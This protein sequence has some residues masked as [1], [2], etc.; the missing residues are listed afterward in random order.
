MGR[1]GRTRGTASEM[2]TAN[3][4]GKPAKMQ[5]AFAAG[6]LT[7]LMAGTLLFGGCGEAAPEE[8][9]EAEDTFTPTDDSLVVVGVS[10]L[11]SESV[12]RT[13]HTASIQRVFTKENGYFLIFENARQK[14]ENQLKAIRSFISQQVDYIVFS[15]ITE[16]GW[17][18]VLE[19][20]RDAGI[21]VILM[22]REVQVQDESLYT[23]WVGSD[24]RQEGEKAGRWLE[25]YL[26]EQSRER[27][28]IRIVILEGT[29]GGTSTIGRNE[30]F[31]AVAAEH[32]NWKILERRDAEF[33]TAKGKEVM[34]GMLAR[35]P[36]IDVVVS[37]NDDMTLGALEALNEAG[38][39]TGVGGDVIVISFDAVHKA[40]ELVADGVINVDIEC[41]PE[42]GEYI[43]EVIRKMEAGEEIDRAYYVPEEVFTQENVGDFLDD[44]TY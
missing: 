36:D 9:T 16:E 33:T 39:T 11:G 25:E 30:G 40:L 43:E 34:E 8:Q 41:N 13:A 28:A 24:F 4:A 20:A 42:Q 18:T 5:A 27:E 31:D 1:F 7:V 22:D 29:Q 19:E 21:P 17:D 37:Q 10:Q 38:K 15:P 6:L 35:H 23:T 12:W 3:T 26:K 32:E 44:R 2:E 14:Q